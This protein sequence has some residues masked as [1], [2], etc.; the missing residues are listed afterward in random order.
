M[1]CC[2]NSINIPTGSVGPSGPSGAN[3]VNG[4]SILYFDPTSTTTTTTSGY[5][6]LKQYTVNLANASLPL[7]NIGDTIRVDIQYLQSS[8]ATSPSSNGIQIKIGGTTYFSH[9][10]LNFLLPNIIRKIELYI[11]RQS[12]TQVWVELKEF[13]YGGI[14]SG[15]TG[16]GY[17]RLTDD[18]MVVTTNWSV[19]SL[20]VNG[21][22]IQALASTP[23]AT[24]AVIC[25]KMLVTSYKIV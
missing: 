17:Q 5:E 1:G 2:D 23:T 8:L 9:G 22:N 11:T 13:S 19:P 24:G 15:Y 10:N 20:S 4:A 3:G 14:S 7:V 21:L 6:V 18:H 12:N 16:G 25:N